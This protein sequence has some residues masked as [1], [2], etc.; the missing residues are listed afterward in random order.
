[1]WVLSVGV[2]ASVGGCG[3]DGSADGDEGST[4]STPATTA[5]TPLDPSAGST[6]SPTQPTAPGTTGTPGDTTEGADSGSTGPQP[7][8]PPVVNGERAIAYQLPVVGTAE[9]G[10]GFLLDNDSDPEGGPLSV[11]P[12]QGSSDLSNDYTITAEGGLTFVSDPAQVGFFDEV[13]FDAIAYTVMDDEG[14]EAEATVNPIIVVGQSLAEPQSGWQIQ[15]PEDALECGHEVVNLGDVNGD[16]FDDLGIGWPEY[17]ADRGRVFVVFGGNDLSD[18]ISLDDVAGGDGGFIID[19]IDD[20]RR[21]GLGLGAI[22]DINDDGFDDIAALDYDAYIIHGSATPSNTTAAAIASGTEGFH[23]S[24]DTQFGDFY[25]DVDGVGDINNDDMD[26]F[27]LGAN[28][29]GSSQA[30]VVWGRTETSNL[31]QGALENGSVGYWINDDITEDS[32]EIAVRGIGDVNADG[33]PDLA[34]VRSPNLAGA[35]SGYVAFGR[36]EGGQVAL[37]TFIEG[38]NGATFTTAETGNVESLAWIPDFDGAGLGAVAIGQASF[39]ANDGR[40]IVVSDFTGAVDLDTD[41]HVYLGSE[42]RTGIDIAAAGDANGDGRGDILIHQTCAPDLVTDGMRTTVAYAT[43]GARP[44]RV[45]QG[46][47]GVIGHI[48]DYPQSA[49]DD[50]YGL[51]GIQRMGQIDFDGDGEDETFFADPRLGTIHIVVP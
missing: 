41:G 17:S 4:G 1:M 30:Y 47:R 33:V 15:C 40:V 48:V 44:T 16:G 12:A 2:A 38:T 34:V 5:N 23:I 19:G 18:V 39:D 43:T 9:F 10:D 22:G 7:N 6:G 8:Q 31:N 32:L 29:T 27:V 36:P 24:R 37:S 3:D 35:P 11:V 49:A 51:A 25:L 21:F 50:E 42:C 26:D 28:A 46:P 45:A 14:L 13:P 20:D